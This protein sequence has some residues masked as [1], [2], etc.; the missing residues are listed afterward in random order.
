MQRKLH[1]SGSSAYGTTKT[2]RSMLIF[3]LAAAAAPVLFLMFIMLQHHTAHADEPRG[4]NTNLEMWCFGYDV[5]EGDDFRLEVERTDCMSIH[6]D[7]QV[8]WNTTAMTAGESDYE[9]QHSE[10]QTSNQQETDDG[11]MRHAFQTKDDPYSERAEAFK[12]WFSTSENGRETDQCV[13]TILD[14]DPVGIY[15][16][17][18]ISK[19]DDRSGYTAGEVIEIAAYFTG[20]VSSRPSGS[21]GPVDYTGIHILVGGERRVTNLLRGNHTFRLVFGYEVQEGDTDSDGISVEAG[22]PDASPETGWVF[23][24]DDG[25]HVG[26]WTVE[27][28]RTEKVNLFYR[29]LNNRARHKVNA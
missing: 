15:K 23:G 18:I 4:Y 24:G 19:P 8:F 3:A 12:I 28:G 14:N 26:L 9:A 10:R 22:N 29:G 17:E 20:D 5:T 27:S 1:I 7:M 21:S 13:V 2:E 11:R 25:S 16:L 6:K